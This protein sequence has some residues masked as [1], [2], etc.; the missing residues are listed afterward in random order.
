MSFHL[1]MP[2]PYREEE[3][4]LARLAAQRN[5]RV[6]A[7]LRAHPAARLDG[8]GETAAHPVSPVPQN[9]RR[10]VLPDPVAFK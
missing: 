9:K 2:L 8:S 10:V 4:T 5:P 6:A 3:M 7:G 1:A